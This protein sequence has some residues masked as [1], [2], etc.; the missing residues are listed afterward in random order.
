MTCNTPFVAMMSGLMTSLSPTVSLAPV[1]VT[2]RSPPPRV[3]SLVSPEA[4]SIRLRGKPGTR[5]C[6]TKSTSSLSSPINSSLGA[7]TVK[8]SDPDNLEPRSELR[9][10]SAKL[11]RSLS[12]SIIS[13]RFFVGFGPLRYEMWQVR[14]LTI[15]ADQIPNLL[16]PPYWGAGPGDILTTWRNKT[17]R[18]SWATWLISV[19]QMRLDS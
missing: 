18:T 19:T 2:T 11:V 10:A 6:I 12:C 3:T 15:I 5:C 14:N 16:F 4:R 9:R 8:K 17:T 7:K 1:L 13:R